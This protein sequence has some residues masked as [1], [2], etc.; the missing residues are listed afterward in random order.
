MYCQLSGE[1][2]QTDITALALASSSSSS[3]L[4]GTMALQ[5]TRGELNE[6][7]VEMKNVIIN[8][9]IDSNTDL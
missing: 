6:V 4:C 1:N 3:S 9:I 8:L 7:F 5:Y 2:P